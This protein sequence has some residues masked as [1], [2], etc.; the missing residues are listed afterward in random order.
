MIDDLKF[1]LADGIKIRVGTDLDP[2]LP[3]DYIPTPSS[4]HELH[5]LDLASYEGPL[6]LLLLLIRRH[7]LD[8]FDIPIAFICERYLACLDVM[9]DMQVDMAS[10]FLLMASELLFIKS[11]LLVP[12][13]AVSDDAEEEGDPRAALVQRLLQYQQ[14]KEAAEGFES[15]TWLGRDVFLREAEN[16]PEAEG[17]PKLKE[18]SIFALVDAFSGMLKR[19]KPEVR[20][21]VLM[22]SVSVSK[23]MQA[24]AYKLVGVEALPFFELFADYQHSRLELVTTFLAVLEMTKLHLMRLYES[25]TGELYVH[26]IF[27]EIDDALARIGGFS[28]DEYGTTAA[29]A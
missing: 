7:K 14:F 8:I 4:G 27:G 22:E 2:A 26:P 1:E 28:D 23:R 29:S 5:Q 3:R 20:H 12:V 10:D 18:V 25:D 24:L 9:E 6:D 17:M 21:R 13:L 16:I 11:K 19:Q 15:L